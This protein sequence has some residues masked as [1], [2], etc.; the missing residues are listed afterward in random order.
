MTSQISHVYQ[1]TKLLSYSNF[2]ALSE[3]RQAQMQKTSNELENFWRDINMVLENS[4]DKSILQNIA[5][6]KYKVEKDPI[7]KSWFELD[8]RVR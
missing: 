6:L 3:E 1:I 5:R 4:N 8:P 7:I 2:L